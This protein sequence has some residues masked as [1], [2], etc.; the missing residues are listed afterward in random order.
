MHA[1]VLAIRPGGLTANYVAPATKTMAVRML[2]PLAPAAEATGPSVEATSLPEPMVAP[3]EKAA[4]AS[5]SP[6]EHKPRRSAATMAAGDAQAATIG[7]AAKDVRQPDLASKPA[8]D[9]TQA[10]GAEAPLPAAP[11]YA[12]GIRLDP[13]PR[14]LEEIEPDYPDAV[15]LREGT[16]VLRLLISDT[17]HVDDVAVVRSQPRGV[18]EQA[19]IDAFAKARFAPG[20]AAGTPVKSQI[21]VEVQFMPINRGARVSGRTY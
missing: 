12:L 15:H 19:A 6:G 2:R 8:T 3:A 21:I 1:A 18:F 17:G 5:A 7:S 16:V 11:E 4:T 9:P 13:G 10:G 20:M 14:P